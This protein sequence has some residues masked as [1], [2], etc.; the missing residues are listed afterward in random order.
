MQ[1]MEDVIKKISPESQHLGTNG[2][3][4]SKKRNRTR[5]TKGEKIERQTRSCFEMSRSLA[6]KGAML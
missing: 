1:T 4:N 2:R 3:K 6:A 5:K